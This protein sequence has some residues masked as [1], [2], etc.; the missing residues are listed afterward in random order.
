[1]PHFPGERDILDQE[2]TQWGPSGL[3]IRWFLSAP[4]IEGISV[5]ERPNVAGHLIVNGDVM[6]ALRRAKLTGYRAMRA[7][8]ADH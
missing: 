1:M 8:V 5:T 7:R 3:P 6:R 2:W 4:K